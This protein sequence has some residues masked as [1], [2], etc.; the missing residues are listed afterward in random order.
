MRFLRL[1]LLEMNWDYRERTSNVYRKKQEDVSRL[2]M[3]AIVNPLNGLM[4]NRI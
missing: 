4:A 1:L 3:N 2:I